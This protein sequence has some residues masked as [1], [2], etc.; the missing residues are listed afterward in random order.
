MGRTPCRPVHMRRQPG[1]QA[2]NV[3]LRVMQQKN[4]ATTGRVGQVGRDR[5]ETAPQVHAPHVTERPTGFTCCS[6]GHG[7]CGPCATDAIET[8]ILILLDL[9]SAVLNHLKTLDEAL[10]T[11]RIPQPQG[12]TYNATSNRR[13]T[14]SFHSRC[15]DSSGWNNRVP[16]HSQCGEYC[17]TWGDLPCDTSTDCTSPALLSHRSSQ[18]SQ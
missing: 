12:H 1:S 5:V 13:R 16:A 17:S 11:L 18:V 4:P 8:L 7:R 6:V 3:C 15:T 14:P 9:G 2:V 10:H